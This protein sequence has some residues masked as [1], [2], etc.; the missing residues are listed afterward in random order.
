MPSFYFREAESGDI[1]GARRSG[2]APCFTLETARS[3]TPIGRVFVGV[4]RAWLSLRLAQP[5]FLSLTFH[6]I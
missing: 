5:P 2:Q 4:P 6:P 3:M 1:I